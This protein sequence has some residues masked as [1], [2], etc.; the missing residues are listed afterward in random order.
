VAPCFVPAAYMRALL[1]PLF[2]PGHG[3]FDVFGWDILF[4]LEDS[5]N[6]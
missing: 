6:T 4:F 1:F 3:C 5:G 2:D